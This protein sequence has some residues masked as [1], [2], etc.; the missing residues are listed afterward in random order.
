[1]EACGFGSGLRGYMQVLYSDI[2]SVLKI[3][4]G[5]S[6]PFNSEGSQTELLLIAH[7]VLPGNISQV[8]TSLVVNKLHNCLLPLKM[9]MKML[10]LR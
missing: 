5:L 9:L 8:K 7:S 1:M 2:K 10:R 6:A 3:N 4:W